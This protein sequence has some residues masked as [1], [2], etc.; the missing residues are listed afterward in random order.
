MEIGVC[1]KKPT[2]TAFILDPPSPLRHRNELADR[3]HQMREHSEPRD[4]E[5][6]AVVARVAE[7]GGPRRRADV[8]DGTR[9]GK[10][11]G[12]NRGLQ[13]GACDSC[14]G[15]DGSGRNWLPQGGGERGIPPGTPVAVRMNV[16]RFLKPV[17]A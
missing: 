8:V 2:N 5:A 6:V 16:V 3:V 15:Q 11:V 7:G 1:T 12:Q 14:G 17:T 9:I 10:R 13:F 4:F